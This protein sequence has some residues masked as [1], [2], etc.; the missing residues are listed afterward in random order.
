MSSDMRPIL[1]IALVFG[2]AVL[3]A[4]GGSGGFI[5]LDLARGD[6][7]R[8]MSIARGPEQERARFHAQYEVPITDP[9]IERMEVITEYRR[10]VLVVEQRLAAGEFAIATNTQLAEAAARPWKRRVS[11][12]TRIRFHPLNVYTEAPRVSMLLGDPK[13]PVPALHMTTD[14][15]YALGDFQVGFA[16]LIGMVVESDYDATAIA[17]RTV[18]FVVRIQGAPDVRVTINF[19][20]FR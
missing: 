6:V 18:P 9:F 19:A 16:P 14:P 4:A 5:A 3:S 1:S 20:T 15:Q 10:M 17:E 8:A 7:E 13:Q 11:I 12:R 2:A